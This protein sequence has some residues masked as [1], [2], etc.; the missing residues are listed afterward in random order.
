MSHY[1]SLCL[2]MSHYVTSIINSTEG[3]YNY[4]M[5]NGKCNPYNI[6][7][8]FSVESSDDSETSSDSSSEDGDGV[9]VVQGSTPQLG[10]NQPLGDWE[11]HTK[12]CTY[13]LLYYNSIDKY[14]YSLTCA[15]QNWSSQ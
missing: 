4:S 6:G 3:T 11:K 7:L 5:L 12:V 2:A 10:T 9:R 13:A 1:V 8:R 15:Q 14:I